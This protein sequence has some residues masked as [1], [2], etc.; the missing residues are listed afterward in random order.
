LNRTPKLRDFLKQKIADY[1]SMTVEWIGGHDPEAWLYSGPEETD[2]MEKL[3][4]LDADSEELAKLFA[5]KGFIMK[6]IVKV[7]PAPAKV[8][9]FQ[10]KSYR[11]FSELYPHEALQSLVVPPERVLQIESAEEDAFLHSW[12][13]QGKHYWLGASDVNEEGVWT[14][15]DDSLPFWTNEGKVADAF[16]AWAPNEPNNANPAGAENCAV[17]AAGGAGWVD[18]PC[19]EQ[20]QLVVESP[21]ETTASHSQEL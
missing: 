18:R 6:R 14:W 7:L 1:E 9:S 5:T 17:F 2:F 12:L 13:D 16:S 4:L 20:H 15:G 21:I 11:V 3:S 8:E 19:S 10:G